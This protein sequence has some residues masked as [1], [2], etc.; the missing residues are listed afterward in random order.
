[1]P[2]S[3][4]RTERRAGLL[5]RTPAEH[6]AC[7]VPPGCSWVIREALCRD[8]GWGCGP[9]RDSAGRRPQFLGPSA[10]AGLTAGAGGTARPALGL[11]STVAGL[12][13][14]GAV[15]PGAGGAGAGTV[16][17]ATA[18]GAGAKST[19]SVAAGAGGGG[20]TP[21]GRLPGGISVTGAAVPIGELLLGAPITVL[22]TGAPTTGP[23]T[24]APATGLPGISRSIAPSRTI[25]RI[26]PRLSASRMG[27]TPGS[28]R[29]DIRVS[30]P[31][32]ASSWYFG[33]G[34]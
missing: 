34:K 7:A 6:V 5:Q 19:G 10:G 12:P 30:T 32:T 20:V 22:L 2:G 16:L 33:S 25:T 29:V 17:G 31:E 27:S 9:S 18:A 13:A 15:S 1:M 8:S 28:S 26:V 3:P 23:L 11:G 24:T 21:G 14:A 4:G